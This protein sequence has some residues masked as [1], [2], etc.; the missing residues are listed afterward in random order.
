MISLISHFYKIRFKKP[1]SLQRAVVTSINNC[2]TAAVAMTCFQSPGSKQ[3]VHALT[4]LKKQ[5]V[6][7]I[8]INLKQHCPSFP[9][10][11]DASWP[12]QGSS[13]EDKLFN[14]SVTL[15]FHITASYLPCYCICSWPRCDSPGWLVAWDNKTPPL[16]RVVYEHQPLIRLDFSAL[17]KHLHTI[18]RWAV[19]ERDAPAM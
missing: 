13:V 15:I 6:P 8:L 17:L 9:V 11:W 14:S 4:W 5:P 10:S 12:I 16:P 3:E 7:V 2:S 19:A 1:L 18:L